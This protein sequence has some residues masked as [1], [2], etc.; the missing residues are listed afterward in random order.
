VNSANP[1][2]A[3]ALLKAM[4]GPESRPV[5]VAAGLEPIAH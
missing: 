1:E 3:R 4:A 5:L 2:A